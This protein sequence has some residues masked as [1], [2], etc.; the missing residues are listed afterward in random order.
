MVT[1]SVCTGWMPF[2][3]LSHQC[4]S[5]NWYWDLWHQVKTVLCPPLIH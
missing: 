1:E 2:L 5:T 4:Q 3:S